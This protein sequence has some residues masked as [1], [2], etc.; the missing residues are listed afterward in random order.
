MSVYNKLEEE[1]DLNYRKHKIEQTSKGFLCSDCGLNAWSENFP[2][3][4]IGPTTTLKL[5]KFSTSEEIFD[6]S[7]NLYHLHNKALITFSTGQVLEDNISFDIDSVNL[8]SLISKLSD[9]NEALKSSL[10]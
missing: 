4:C 10:K 9:I 7:A 3:Y 6:V 5:G 2:E 8:E 1:H